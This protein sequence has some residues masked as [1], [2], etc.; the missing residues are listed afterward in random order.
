MAPIV[1]FHLVRFCLPGMPSVPCLDKRESTMSNDA[2]WVSDA[3]L[4]SLS[5]Q[6]RDAEARRAEAERAHQLPLVEAYRAGIG[7]DP[8]ILAKLSSAA[9]NFGLRVGPWSI[10]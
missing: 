1:G 7:K 8:L 5:M 2:L 9:H 3:M 10:Y 6:L 4:D